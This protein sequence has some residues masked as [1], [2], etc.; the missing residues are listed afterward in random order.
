VGRQAELD[1][2]RSAVHDRNA[3][4]VVI[5]V[6]GPGGVGKTTLLAEFA[7]IAHGAGRP[8]IA[9]DAR[10]AGPSR[11]DFCDALVEAGA[12]PAREA[13]PP[14]VPDGAVVLLDTYESVAALDRWL[15][16]TLLPAWPPDVLVVLAG[17]DAPAHAWTTDPGWSRITNAL[18][19]ANLTPGESR[20]FLEAR[21]I[22]R[23]AHDRALAFTHGHP[24]ALALVAR[25]H[26]ERSPQAPFDPVDSPDV[27][28]HLWGLFLDNVP[29]ARRAALEACAVARVTSERLLVR[30]FG[31]AEGRAAFDWLRAQPFIHAGSGGLVPH[32]LVRELLVAEARWRDSAALVSLSR[33]INA[34]LHAEIGAARGRDAHRLKMDALYVTRV[35]PTNAGFFDWGALEARVERAEE[36]DL[37]WI[38]GLVACHEGRESA[39]LARGW[40]AA[41]PGA[42]QVFRDKDD[43]RFGFLALVEFGPESLR[44][45]ADPALVAARRF[46]DAHGPLARG[47]IAVHLRFWMHAEAYQAVTAAI[48]LTAMHVVSHCLQEPGL[49]WNFVAMRDPAFWG[50]HFDGVNFPRAPGAD[51]DVDGRRYGVFAHDWRVEPPSEWLIGTRPTMP[52]AASSDPGAER[53]LALP[54]FRQAIRQALRDYTRADA[55]A[56]GPLRLSRLVPRGTSDPAEAIRRLLTEAAEAVRAEPRGDEL[57]R[58]LSH[59]YFEPLA[60][61]ERVAER[62]GLPFSTY[63][64]H[65]TRGIERVSACLWERERKAPPR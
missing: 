49:A 48:N 7:R 31:E 36:A 5:H 44:A 43:K 21:G 28:R 65:L 8:V 14:L 3:G 53:S 26:A 61:Q 51:Y 25:V 19:V 18:P 23:G 42:F 58:V 54:E 4:L 2:F 10:D 34:A 30:L 35:R 63:R 45:P 22:D 32:D 46:V 52:F 9:L 24:L 33:R 47:E 13:S 38:L 11:A 27:V 41:Q 59:T 37:D 62:L 55:L 15:R 40:W 64:R 60:S 17:R 1:L 29:E 57:H 12:R 56:R 39:E 16:E 6:H 50:E 20:T